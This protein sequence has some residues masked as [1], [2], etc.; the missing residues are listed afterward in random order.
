M[1]NLNLKEITDIKLLSLLIN[2]LKFNKYEKRKLL[3]SNNSEEI[4][5]FI[6]SLL[7]YELAIVESRSEAKH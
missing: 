6:T 7:E 2:Q 3:R 5:S 1:N 4:N